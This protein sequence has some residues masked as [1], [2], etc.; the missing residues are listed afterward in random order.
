MT[1]NPAVA[2]KTIMAEQELL[3][4]ALAAMTCEVRL[5]TTSKRA[6]LAPQQ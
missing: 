6:T 1:H 5:L 2:V 4:N 3:L